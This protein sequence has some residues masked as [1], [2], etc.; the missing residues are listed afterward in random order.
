MS[1]QTG[2]R[3]DYVTLKQ[4]QLDRWNS[5]VNILEAKAAGI[6]DDIVEKYNRQ[7]LVV[8]SRYKQSLVK[9][10]AIRDAGEF[11]WEH[12]KSETESVMDSFKFAIDQF[13]LH[14]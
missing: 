8:R 3:D 5:E 2:A 11:S 9:L 4:A 10:D 6:K 12:L 7:I 14:F 13:Q 1:N